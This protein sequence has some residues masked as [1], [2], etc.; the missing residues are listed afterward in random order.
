M[1]WRPS[2]QTSDSAGP[3]TGRHRDS[4][5]SP[6]AVSAIKRAFTRISDGIGPAVATAPSSYSSRAPSIDKADRMLSPVLVRTYEA[7]GAARK[8]SQGVTRLAVAASGLSLV[9]PVL[10]SYVCHDHEESN[11]LETTFHC[12]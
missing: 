4:C 1:D 6:A 10:S 12:V 9:H 5:D 3:A 8:Q 7:V 2:R 11:R